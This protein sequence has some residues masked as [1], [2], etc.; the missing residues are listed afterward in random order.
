MEINLLKKYPK[1]KRNLKKRTEEKSSDVIKIARKFGR[2]FFDGHRKYGYGGFNYDKKYWRKVT[3]DLIRHY[4]LN[5]N[6]SVLDVGCGKGFMLYDFKKNLKNLRVYGID[7]SSYAIKNG[8]KEIKKYLKVGNAKKL[9]FPDNSFDLVIAIN[10][11]HNL[12]KKDCAKALKEIS[13]VSKK[14]SY[15]VLDAYKSESEKK[16]M[17]AWNLTGKTIMHRRKWISFLKKNKYQGDYYWFNP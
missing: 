14:N 13:R 5:D 3:Q 8:K 16:K 11:I 6:S 7:I 4:R 1:T 10:T 17:L 2:D 9:Q 12:N 15:I